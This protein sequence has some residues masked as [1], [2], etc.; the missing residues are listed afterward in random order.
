MGAARRTA[1]CGNGWYRT[2]AICGMLLAASGL[3]VAFPPKFDLLNRN[4]QSIAVDLKGP[5]AWRPSI[6]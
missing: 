6:I 3:G 2:G 5:K 1:R 4:K